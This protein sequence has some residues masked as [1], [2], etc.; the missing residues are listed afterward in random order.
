MMYI[1]STLTCDNAYA[2]YEPSTDAT[3][4][5]IIKRTILIKGGHGVANKYVQT[6]RGVVTEVS[7]ED[8]AALQLDAH[9]QQHVK[10]GFITYEK[11]KAD[12]ESVAKNM[13]DRDASAP[14]IP[15]E[16]EEIQD[17]EGNVRKVYK[18]R[19]KKAN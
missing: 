14:L 16:F 15:D 12:T 13:Q 4:I 17:K 9:F 19:G 18:P 6:P 5:S 2:V 7:D 3:Q 1:Y 8:F 10:N 11:S